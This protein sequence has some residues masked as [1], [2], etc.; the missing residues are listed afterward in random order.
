M[1]KHIRETHL[2]EK[3]HKCTVCDEAF[4][5]SGQLL[6]HKKTVHEG[7][8]YI[9]E[10]CNQEFKGPRNMKRHKLTVHKKKESKNI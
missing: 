4:K 7:V 1:K 6:L 3:N 5:R 2:G 10:Q 9:C 8:K